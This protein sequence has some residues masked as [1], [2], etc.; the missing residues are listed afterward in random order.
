MSAQV[1]SNRC[2]RE[3]GDSDVTGVWAMVKPGDKPGDRAGK[4]ATGLHKT[5]RPMSP[6]AEKAL[7]TI[8]HMISFI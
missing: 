2:T 6:L 5:T 3:V 1:H 7:K 8:F 4:S